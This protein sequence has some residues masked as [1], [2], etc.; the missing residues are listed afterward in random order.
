MILSSVYI[1]CFVLAVIYM[2]TV[3]RC[4]FNKRTKV[5]ITILTLSML[6]QGTASALTYSNYSRLDGICGVL[7]LTYT[8]LSQQHIIIIVIY[9]FL[10]CRMLSI[11]YKM[12]IV[13]NP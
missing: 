7:P 13:T 1:F 9:S 12:S 8:I 5:V 2:F 4:K 3:N 10:V 6:L 11:Y